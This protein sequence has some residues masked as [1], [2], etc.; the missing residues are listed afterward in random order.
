LTWHYWNPGIPIVYNNPCYIAISLGTLYCIIGTVY[1]LDFQIAF[2]INFD[3]RFAE[4]TV[5]IV[6]IYDYF[7]FIYSNLL[8]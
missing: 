5:S 4:Q 6:A 8:G 7:D 3:Y 2:S 1:Y